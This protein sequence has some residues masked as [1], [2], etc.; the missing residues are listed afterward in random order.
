MD[1][2]DST[3]NPLQKFSKD[4]FALSTGA[5]SPINLSLFSSLYTHV[6]MYVCILFNNFIQNL[7]RLTRRIVIFLCIPVL[8]AINIIP[9]LFWCMVYMMRLV[10]HGIGGH[11]IWKYTQSVTPWTC[12]QTSSQCLHSLS[13]PKVRHRFYGL[14]LMIKIN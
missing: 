9:F 11:W 12:L 3:I 14:L 10:H 6:C 13:H 8:F 7:H 5:T 2:L 4:N 1:A